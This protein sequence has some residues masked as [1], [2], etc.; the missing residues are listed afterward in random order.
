MRLDRSLTLLLAQLAGPARR[1]ALP[2]LMYHSVDGVLTPGVHPYFETATS[3]ERFAMHMRT[4]ARQGYR[5]V[6]L[7]AALTLSRRASSWAR[8]LR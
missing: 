4:L 2:V 1:H 8:W 7:R 5:A 3:P 6:S